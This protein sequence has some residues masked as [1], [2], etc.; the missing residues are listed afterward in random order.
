L[1]P[2][3]FSAAAIYIYP[4]MCIL[5]ISAFF[6]AGIGGLFSG[7]W[8]QKIWLWACVIIVSLLLVNVYLPDAMSIFFQQLA[9]SKPLVGG[10]PG[11]G[12]A[13]DLLVVSR[14][15]AALWGFEQ[16]TILDR[17]TVTAG[18]LLGGLLALITVLGLA[19]ALRTRAFP[20]ALCFATTVGLVIVMIVSKRYDYG[21]Y[22]M[23]LLGWWATALLLSAGIRYVWS[24][25]PESG[26]RLGIALKAL[27]AGALFS[28]MALWGNQ[29]LTWMEGFAYK[30]AQP[31]REV[32]DYL[33]NL[34][35]VAGASISD[36]I[37]N[38]WMVFELRD[39]PVSFSEYNGYM[40]QAH[41]LP[42][43]TQSV[44]PRR[45]GNYLLVGKATLAAGKVVW[46]NALFNV[47]KNEEGSPLA[48]VG[49]IEAPNGV[50]RVGGSTF[51][52]L[53]HDPAIVSLNSNI[54]QTVYLH[55]DLVGGS[56]VGDWSRP[57]AIEIY[58]D[59]VQSDEFRLSTQPAQSIRL[60]LHEGSNK[61]TFKPIY[62]GIVV[63][64]PNG[65]SR[66]LIAGVKLRTLELFR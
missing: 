1:I 2:A 50:E 61:V 25:F 8:R 15:P 14:L 3:I 51:F 32:R 35:Q 64:N 9:T 42:F 53:G 19:K 21:A 63:S 36:P 38:G 31:L 47:L 34:H 26:I 29:Q 12:F 48:T 4:E 45:S 49:K 30:Q 18:M 24:A 13:P 56:S 58:V 55:A 33:K 7:E 5:V 27:I 41:V 11:N 16:I 39:L 28:A 52:W 65:D 10:R 23:L 62:A 57:V 46:S 20:L 22:K 43:M 60:N 6:I 59:G 37:L 17:S 44:V 40:G 54:V 66:V